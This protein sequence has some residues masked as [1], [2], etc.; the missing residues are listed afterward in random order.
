[1]DLTVV[2]PHQLMQKWGD[3]PQFD[4]LDLQVLS[5]FVAPDPLRLRLSALSSEDIHIPAHKSAV[6]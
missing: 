3:P 4:S 5:G 6:L 2:L 1:M